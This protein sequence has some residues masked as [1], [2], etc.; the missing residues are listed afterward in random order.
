MAIVICEAGSLIAN[1]LAIVM[2]KH[3]RSPICEAGSLIAIAKA[4]TLAIVDTMVKYGRSKLF[5]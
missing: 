1:T 5:L 3:W 4:H 2:V